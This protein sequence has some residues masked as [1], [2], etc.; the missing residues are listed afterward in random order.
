MK[1]LEISF[2]FWQKKKERWS[3][4]ILEKNKTDWRSM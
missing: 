1:F 4:N 3:T 2:R